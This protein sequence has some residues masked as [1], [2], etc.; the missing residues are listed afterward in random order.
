[1]KLGG[2]LNKENRGKFKASYIDREGFKRAKNGNYTL[3]GRDAAE[4]WPNHS[5]SV[6][7]VFRTSS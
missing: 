3:R 1:V 2:E 4:K 5:K 6:L 7:M